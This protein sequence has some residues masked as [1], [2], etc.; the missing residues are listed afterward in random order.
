MA[1]MDMVGV[2]RVFL[3]RDG[4]TVDTLGNATG[5]AVYFRGE[6]G[7][8]TLHLVDDVV[9]AASIYEALRYK[10]HVAASVGAAALGH[11]TIPKSI[12]HV[13]IVPRA[14]SEAAALEASCQI[15]AR[16]DGLR[17]TV[18][19][20]PKEFERGADANDVLRANGPELLRKILVSGVAAS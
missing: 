19:G 4:V 3:N 18:I 20:L 7:A 1:S 12:E 15:A 6:S 16:H 2:Q 17:V 13:I 10:A 9:P 14:G 8:K 11:V 5:S